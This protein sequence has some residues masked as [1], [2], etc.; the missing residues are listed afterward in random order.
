MLDD[1][2]VRN[3]ALIDYKKAY[4]IKWPDRNFPKG[5]TLWI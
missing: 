3:Q 4:F 5:G 2:L 1:H